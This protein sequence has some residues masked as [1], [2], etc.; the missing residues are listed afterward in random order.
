NSVTMTVNAAST[1]YQDSDGDGF[2]NP[3]A[4]AT[5]CSAPTG[6]VVNNSDCDDT[7]SSINPGSTEVCTNSNDDNCNGAINENCCSIT[8]SATTTNSNCTASANGSID[9]TVNG[10]VSPTYLWSNGASTQDLSNVAPG[11]Y[12]V[13]VTDNGCTQQGSYVV[14]N[15]N[16]VQS[17]PTAIDGP[18]GVCR[19]S[20]GNVFTTPVVAGATSYQWTLP[21][22]ATGSS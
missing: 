6:Y 8:L 10:G 21:T 14:G 17:A 1:F 15:N 12:S 18:A 2:G 16:Q 13:T 11:T 19:N 22:G 5:G 9:L 20:T 3:T 7:N 4:T